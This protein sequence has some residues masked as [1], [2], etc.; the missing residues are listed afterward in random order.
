MRVTVRSCKGQRTKTKEP[1]LRFPSN[2]RNVLSCG[3]I[4][5]LTLA[6]RNTVSPD[7]C[8]GGEIATKFHQSLKPYCHTE[9]FPPFLAG[10]RERLFSSSILQI[11]SSLLKFAIK[12]FPGGGSMGGFTCSFCKQ[13]IRLETAKTDENG[14]ADCYLLRLM[15][16][17]QSRG[18]N[19]PNNSP[20]RGA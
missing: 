17:L 20:T 10:E 11:Q 12:P 3:W 2:L 19:T 16:L 9:P 6:V 13:P 14:E 5:R 4:L 15:A 7:R 1:F 8:N 18:H